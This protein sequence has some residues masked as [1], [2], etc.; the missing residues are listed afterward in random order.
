MG[1][2][3]AGSYRLADA[4]VRLMLARPLVCSES[5]PAAGMP[6]V[7]CRGGRQQACQ[8]G[9]EPR[10]PCGGH[11]PAI[12]SAEQ[13]TADELR[14]GGNEGRDLSLRDEAGV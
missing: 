4:L 12:T 6:E 3:W 1:R 8:Q 5:D 14:N 10:Q 13:R 7:G 11:T 9:V 2:G